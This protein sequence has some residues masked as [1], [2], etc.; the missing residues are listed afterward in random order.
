MKIEIENAENPIGRLFA[1]PPTIESETELKKLM[2]SEELLQLMRSQGV[3]RSELARRMGVQP[4]R[5]TSMFSGANN[6]TIE[7]LIRAGRA[8]GA[9]LHQTFCPKGRRMRWASYDPADTHVS[10]PSAAI[11]PTKSAESHFELLPTAP[12]DDSQAA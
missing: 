8:L 4:S 10:F 11:R 5:V 2:I 12:N 6:F 1:A 3:S 9:E 7:T